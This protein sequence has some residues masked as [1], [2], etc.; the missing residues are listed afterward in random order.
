ML[1]TRYGWRRLTIVTV[2]ACLAAAA[3]SSEQ[4]TEP[5]RSRGVTGS[6]VANDQ[7][8]RLD[9]VASGSTVQGTATYLDGT[10]PPTPIVQ[11]ITDSDVGFRVVTGESL[12]TFLDPPQMVQEGWR[13]TAEVTGDRMIGTISWFGVAGR[14]PRVIQPITFVRLVAH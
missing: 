8:L 4:P 3:C 1:S 13:I 12:V 14:Y 7:R 9:L 11:E 10:A 6:W 5:T 2:L